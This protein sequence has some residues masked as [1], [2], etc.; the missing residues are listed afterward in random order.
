MCIFQSIC[1]EAAAAQCL[2]G[3]SEE[4]CCLPETTT[5]AMVEAFHQGET[6]GGIF[7]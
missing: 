7:W 1:Q 4:L 5:L 6:P 2:E 3:P